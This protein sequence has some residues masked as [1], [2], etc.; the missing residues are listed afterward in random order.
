M[1]NTFLCTHF[2]LAQTRQVLVTPKKRTRPNGSDL[3]ESQESAPLP[4]KTRRNPPRGCKKV[5]QM[6][7]GG[8]PGRKSKK[9]KKRKENAGASRPV[10][11]ASQSK[12]LRVFSLY[13]GLNF[14]HLTQVSYSV[15]IGHRSALSTYC[16]GAPVHI[17]FHSGNGVGSQTSAGCC[18]AMGCVE[19]DDSLGRR[20]RLHTLFGQVILQNGNG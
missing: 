4:E 16:Q 10:G 6:K 14:V 20:S 17:P 9:A 15:A 18:R 13:Q 1:P 8:Q 7:D 11:L 19:E 5:T 2:L 3:E 12:E